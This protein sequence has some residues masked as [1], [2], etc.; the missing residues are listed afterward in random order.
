[1]QDLA[2]TQPTSL[3]LILAPD[4]S[5]YGKCSFV[6]RFAHPQVAA[7]VLSTTPRIT[8]SERRMYCTITESN[9]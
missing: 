2:T 9:F 3:A 1:M 4:V 8:T 5:P 6:K 7:C